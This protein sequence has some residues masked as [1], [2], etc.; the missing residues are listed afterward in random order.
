MHLYEFI[1]ILQGS[2][3]PVILIS[4]AGLLMLSMTNRFARVLDRSRH[5][6]ETLRNAAAPEQRYLEKQLDIL[7]RRARL[8][9][10]SITFAVLSVLLVA[11]LVIVLFLTAFFNLEIVLLAA[12]LFIL[13][14]TSL[15]VSLLVF[16]QD[17][18]LSL[19][20]LKLELAHK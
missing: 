2:V 4:G 10:T 11:I 20:A 5:T 16:L 13:C 7:V 12:V 15:V 6:L 8:L 3:G 9:R 17:I 14:L 19:A 1:T 18:S